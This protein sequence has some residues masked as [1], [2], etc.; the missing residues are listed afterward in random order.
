LLNVVVRS[1]DVQDRDGALLVLD[2]CTRRLF[3]F[4]EHIFA[5]PGYQGSKAA[6]A[7]ARTGTW[8]LEI[9]KRN[10]PHRSVV[11]PKR[12]IV[13]RTLARISHNLQHKPA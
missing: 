7:I 10:V 13:E 5:D 1:A 2:R 4:I 9:I 6:A 8:K 3:P 11:L 12:W